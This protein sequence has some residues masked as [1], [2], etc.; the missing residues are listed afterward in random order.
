MFHGA[1][2]LQKWVWVHVE[3]WYTV[4][5]IEKCTENFQKDDFEAILANFGLSRDRKRRK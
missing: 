2:D 4:K 1:P 3:G 5:I